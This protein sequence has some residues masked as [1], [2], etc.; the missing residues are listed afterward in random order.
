[1]LGKLGYSLDMVDMFM[2]LAHSY[3]NPLSFDSLV[4]NFDAFISENFFRLLL[5]AI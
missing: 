3:R 1:M 5:L 2:L 4:K